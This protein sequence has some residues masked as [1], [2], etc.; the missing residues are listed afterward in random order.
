MTALLAQDMADS[1]E[2]DYDLW[3]RRPWYR[4]LLEYLLG[5]VDA[6]LMRLK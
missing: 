5:T 6:W 4:R 1:I 2:Y 3:M